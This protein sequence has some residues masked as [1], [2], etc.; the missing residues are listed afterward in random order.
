L[1]SSVS[2][3]KKPGKPALSASQEKIL[4]CIQLGF[5]ESEDPTLKTAYLNHAALAIETLDDNS[6]QTILTIL[7][8]NNAQI[9]GAQ[10]LLL[11]SLLFYLSKSDALLKEMASLLFH[12]ADS[13]EQYHYLLWKLRG[14]IF[15]FAGHLQP[16]TGAWIRENCMRPTYLQV[17]ETINQ[18]IQNDTLFKPRPQIKKV[19][20]VLSQFIGHLHAPSRTALMIATGL[21]R[22]YGLEVQI[23]NANLVPVTRPLDYFYCHMPFVSD[24]LVGR[25]QIAYCDPEFGMHT[26]T[27]YSDQARIFTLERLLSLWNYIE[28]E[29]FDAFINLGDSLFAID[30][31]FGKIPILSIPTQRDL[32]ISLCDQALLVHETL[33]EDE[34][35]LVKQHSNRPP[36]LNFSLNVTP[37]KSETSLRKQDFDLP[38]EAFV[39]VVVGNRLGFELDSAF[40]DLVRNIADADERNH[41]LFVGSEFKVQSVLTQQGL[42]QHTRIRGVNF[43][44]DLRGFYSLCDVYLNPN[45]SG[46][47]VS[48]QIAM[49]EHLSVLTL[50]Y[51]D[52]SAL[53]PEEYRCA[54]YAELQERAIAFSQNPTLL[55]QW[56]VIMA[57]ISAQ[58]Q[59]GRHNVE[60]IH[61]LLTALHGD[62]LARFEREHGG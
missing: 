28:A 25:Q 2:K 61:Q 59:S 24:K 51:G 5:E 29:D 62:T 15:H 31:F 42:S 52:V 38:E 23:I 58:R 21:M 55:E 46:G 56:K 40:M 9:A 30:Y 47:G 12:Y 50:N 22:D 4:A 3:K 6:R 26:L 20:I 43:Q 13:L 18:C 34:L 35:K 10:K 32:P 8:K 45:R 17:Q 54:S 60:I 33:T 48:A 37:H 53:L 49:A 11:K 14:S 16:D 1:R 19:A 57:D 41:V 27:V 36:R 39:Y 44:A 7:L